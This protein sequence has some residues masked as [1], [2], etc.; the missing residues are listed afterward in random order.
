MKTSSKRID[1]EE[2]KDISLLKMV[3]RAEPSPFL[4]T[5]VM[6]AIG[7]KVQER[8]PLSWAA[9]LSFGLL[10]LVWLN[11]SFI[12][13]GSDNKENVLVQEARLA[14]E[15]NMDLTNQLYND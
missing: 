11:S 12:L 4:K 13:N 5:R 14:T 10:L 9:S 15:L 1:M 2:N 6:A 7:S 8:M 3:K